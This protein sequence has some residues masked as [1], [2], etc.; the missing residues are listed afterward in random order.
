M[1]VA[2]NAQVLNAKV[3]DLFNRAAAMKRQIQVDRM[4]PATMRKAES[5]EA[6]RRAIIKD[7]W[8]HKNNLADVRHIYSMTVHKSQGSTLDTAIVD[9]S[10]MGRIRNDFDYNRSPISASSRRSN[11][12]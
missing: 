8:A 3:S 1:P 12:A 9:L 4:L 11:T 7:A 2:D 6:E 5:D 10:D